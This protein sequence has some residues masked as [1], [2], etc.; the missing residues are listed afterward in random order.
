MTVAFDAQLLH[1][2]E[3]VSEYCR[4]DPNYTKQELL[5]EHCYSALEALYEATLGENSEATESTMISFYTLLT[6]CGL[7]PWMLRNNET[8]SSAY[9]Q[10]K[11]LLRSRL[12][13]I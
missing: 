3:D 13:E 9:A 2:L 10:C 7:T 1:L 12:K 8:E 11:A 5:A 6:N 4:S